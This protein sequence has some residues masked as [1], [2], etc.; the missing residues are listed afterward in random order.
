MIPAII[1]CTIA[2]PAVFAGILAI[3]CVQPEPTKPKP[4]ENKYKDKP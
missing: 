1:C 2:T 4:C 3:A